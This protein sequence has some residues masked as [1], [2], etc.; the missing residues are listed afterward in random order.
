MKAN[1]LMRVIALALSALMMVLLFAGCAVADTTAAADGTASG[2]GWSMIIMIVLMIAV[3][4]FFLIRPEQKKRKETEQMRDTLAIGEE[5][6]TIGGITGKVVQVTDD[7]VTFETGED[8][9]RIQVKKWGISTTAKF[10]AAKATQKKG[11][12]FG[13]RRQPGADGRTRP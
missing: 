7:T 2:G 12:A 13:G 6:V 9:V 4:Y 3:F 11:G 5:I 1:R 10:D 8:R